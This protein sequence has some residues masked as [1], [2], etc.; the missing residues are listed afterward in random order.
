MRKAGGQGAD[1]DGV[2]DDVQQQELR[3]L[4]LLA[5]QR[6]QDELDRIHRDY[7]MRR[8]AL[9]RDSDAKE[10]AQLQAK[11]AEEIRVE[12]R[13]N[14]AL[15]ESI[16]R[17]AKD[18]NQTLALSLGASKLISDKLLVDL[19]AAAA[20][21]E[22]LLRRQQALNAIDRE[23]KARIDGINA[24]DVRPT[25]NNDVTAD[26]SGAAEANATKRLNL[27]QRLIKRATDVEVDL[28][29]QKQRQILEAQIEGNSARLVQY[30]NDFSEQAVAAKS[31][32]IDLNKV[33]G[34]ALN[35]LQAPTDKPKFSIYKLLLGEKENTE[36]NRQ[37]LDQAVSATLGAIGQMLQAEQSLAQAKI[38]ARTRNIDDLN[39]RLT[40]EIQ[41]NKE[42]SASNI[43]GL[44]EQ[45]AQEKQERREAVQERRRAAKEQIIIDTLLQSSSIVTAAAQAL[46]AFPIPFVGPALG[47]GAAAL[48]I[49]AFVTSKV[50]A[51]QAVNS[52]SE[53]FFKGGYTGGNSIHEERGPVHGKE[54]VVDN[55]KTRDNR[56]FLEAL[57]N[58][59]LH[60]LSWQ[61]PT[62]LK[63]RN[64]V[65][66]NPDLPAQIREQRQIALRVQH[67][68]TYAPL[69][70]ELAETNRKLD[71]AVRQLALIPKETVHAERPGDTRVRHNTETN[72]TTR[73]K[74]E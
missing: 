28:E 27:V 63:I 34:E 48:I 6:F 12:Q 65:E 56:L 2:L 67:E 22:G 51:L 53:G 35:K 13:A 30:E 36:E 39:T 54:F 61:D 68:H 42:G 45:I 10:L 17:A 62:L 18:G 47:I 58:D 4:R 72:T 59:E 32:L 71:E 41:L 38:D 29:K 14:D 60:K 37:Q 52:Q 49:S 74:I 50:K 11:F 19:R 20:E 5:E 23:E 66:L 24:G 7:A 21:Q 57:H 40:Q 73:T 46:T 31:G 9:Q 15:G 1:A 43:A 64:E 44:R 33:L 55:R 8:L 25:Q 69:K 70:A 26:G 16:E 3:T